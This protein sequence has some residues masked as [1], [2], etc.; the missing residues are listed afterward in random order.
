MYIYFDEYPIYSGTISENFERNFNVN[1]ECDHG[2]E[3]F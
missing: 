1:I 3:Y 2:Y